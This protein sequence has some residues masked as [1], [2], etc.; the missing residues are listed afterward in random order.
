V[1]YQDVPLRHVPTLQ[2]SPDALD[3]AVKEIDEVRG[4]Y[5]AAQGA[6]VDDLHQ[7]S[8]V[9]SGWQIGAACTHL[10]QAWGE[11]FKVFDRNLKALGEALSACVTA[12]RNQDEV[13][14]TAFWYLK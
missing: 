11:D 3:T 14:A 9:L 6:V 8:G 5:T 10:E 2:V 12:Y 1:A 13:S 7:T 4:N